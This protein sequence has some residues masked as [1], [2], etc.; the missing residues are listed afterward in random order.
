ME[1]PA[2]DDE[3]LHGLVKLVDHDFR[4]TVRQRPVNA[5]SIGI[6][7]LLLLRLH[8]GLLQR[9]LTDVPPPTSVSA[10]GGCLGVR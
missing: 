9:R 7:L 6:V 10:G 8:I 1:P 5:M 4:R 2:T 3:V